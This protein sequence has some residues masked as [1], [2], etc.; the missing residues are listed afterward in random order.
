MPGPQSIDYIE[1]A[2][3]GSARYGGGLP[4]RASSAMAATSRVGAILSRAKYQPSV[5]RSASS[6]VTVVAVV[7]CGGSSR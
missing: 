6:V 2:V 5:A 7:N 4:W 3:R 1:L